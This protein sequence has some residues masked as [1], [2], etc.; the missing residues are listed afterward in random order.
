MT[1]FLQTISAMISP[2]FFS[3]STSANPRNVGVFLSIKKH[4]IAFNRHAHNV[5]RDE[6][7][8]SRKNKITTHVTKL[9]I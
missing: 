1:I 9:P 8:S 5:L 6:T 4:W 3:S 2:V 7:K